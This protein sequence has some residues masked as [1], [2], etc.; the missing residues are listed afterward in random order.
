[1]MTLEEALQ[2]A[3]AVLTDDLIGLVR[4]AAAEEVRRAFESLET[5]GDPA[6]LRKAGAARPP[7]PSA[8]S[9]R[10]LG[11]TEPELAGAP[12]SADR[13]DPTTT[14]VGP[15][16]DTAPERMAPMST[17]LRPADESSAAAPAAEADADRPR[18]P[19]PVDV[20][21]PDHEGTAPPQLPT[22]LPESASS[23]AAEASP[24][25]KPA[26]DRRPTNIAQHSP[27]DPSASAP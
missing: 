26:A 12:S 4:R 5:A 11:F 23:H 3:V 15:P 9:T 7:K 25:R 20:R 27:L 18:Q 2:A 21:N 14:P 17:A 13:A 24:P 1:M 10:A 22:P 19:E 16:G 8:T 6:G